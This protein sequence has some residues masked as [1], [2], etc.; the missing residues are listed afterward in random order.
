MR[1]RLDP[2]MASGFVPLLDQARVTGG[3]NASVKPVLLKRYS[4]APAGGGDGAE[5]T[6]P[7]RPAIL[8]I[9][10][11]RDGT[12]GALDGTVG[13]WGASLPHPDGQATNV[14]VFRGDGAATT[15]DPD[16]TKMPYAL[17]A[18]FNWIVIQDGVVLDQGAGAGKYQISNPGTTQ[19][20]VTLGTVAPLGSKLEVYLVVPVAVFAVAAAAA[21]RKQVI[22]NDIM[23]LSYV[24]ASTNLSRTL[25]T[26]K[27][28]AN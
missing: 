9:S 11:D 6:A 18:N 5:R 26:L 15:F 25:A 7:G 28:A 14:Q 24:V 22:V 27:P 20:R 3:A 10:R 1:G 8:E 17:F 19:A 13:V 23:W 21:E 16:L 12:T 4:G 2:V